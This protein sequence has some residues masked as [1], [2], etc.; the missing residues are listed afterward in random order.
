MENG[1]FIEKLQGKGQEELLEAWYDEYHRHAFGIGFRE[2][3]GASPNLVQVFKRWCAVI[4]IHDKVCVQ[5]NYCQKKRSIGPSAQLAAALAD[6][7][8][9][10]IGLTV[11]GALSVALLLV[12]HRFD[13]IC[14]CDGKAPVKSP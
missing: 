12:Q 9:P 13:S 11:N 5:W 2:A 14:D 4:S 1:D 10:L 7:L 8:A 3:A 6:F